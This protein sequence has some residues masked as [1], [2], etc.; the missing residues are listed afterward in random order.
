V[1]GEDGYI[2]FVEIIWSDGEGDHLPRP[3]ELTAP[4]AP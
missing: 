3:D 1:A 4:T 2:E